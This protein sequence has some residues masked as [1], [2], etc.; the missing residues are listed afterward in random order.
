MR[1][2]KKT[3]AIVLAA[4]QGKRMNSNVQKQYMELSGK[5]VVFYSLETFEQSFVDEIVLVVGPNEVAYCKENIVDKYSFQ[6]VKNIV[7]GGACRYHS[8]FNGLM[9]AGVCD[10]VFIHDGARPFVDILIL[11][12]CYDA[13]CKNM[14]CVVGMPAKDTVRIADE[15]EFSKMTP[16]RKNVWLMQTPQVFQYDLIM[17]AYRSLMEEE[18]NILDRG[19]EITDDVMVLERFSSVLVKFVPGSYEN[20]KITTPE[21]LKIGESFFEK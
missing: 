21:D 6:K 12:R 11:E 4:G 8:V 2:G 14:A 17:E 9:A 13:V 7:V 3:V 15:N 18:Q 10:Y 19:I 1:D 16:S 20:I 5:P